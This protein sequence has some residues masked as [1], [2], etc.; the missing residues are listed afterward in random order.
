[1]RPAWMV[2]ELVVVPNAPAMLDHIV[3]GTKIQPPPGAKAGSWRQFVISREMHRGGSGVS[4]PVC[5]ESNLWVK[6]TN[7]EDRDFH[8][9]SG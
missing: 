7:K 6:I 9:G 4:R 8:Q 1:M 3:I 5:K 2:F